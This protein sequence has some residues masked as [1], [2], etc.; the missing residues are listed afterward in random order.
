V[1][2]QERYPTVVTWWASED[3]GN[4]GAPS[5]LTRCSCWKG[6]FRSVIQ[7]PA[8]FTLSR[9]IGTL[10]ILWRQ[11]F[12]LSFVVEKGGK[13]RWVYLCELFI[14][15]IIFIYEINIWSL[16]VDSSLLEIQN[17]LLLLWRYQKLMG[18]PKVS[19]F[20]DSC[21]SNTCW[22]LICTFRSV[23]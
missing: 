3:Q 1:S 12:L 19:Y 13:Q 6:L 22:E 20:S 17:I 15:N 23:L 5:I 8:G 7:T 2:Q 16:N 18:H 10:S 9:F 21:Y 4:V 11:Y 14:Y